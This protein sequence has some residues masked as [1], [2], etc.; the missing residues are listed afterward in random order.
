M[1]E[2]TTRK[3]HIAIACTSM[4][5]CFNRTEIAHSI[6]DK[7]Q[8]MMRTEAF[9]GWGSKANKKDIAQPNHVDV[10]IRECQNFARLK[11]QSRGT[12]LRMQRAAART[13]KGYDEWQYFE[14]FVLD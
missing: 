2:N 8:A 6:A 4:H 12:K 9:A 10:F 11:A 3:Q 14:R 1:H 5:L 7:I 13:C